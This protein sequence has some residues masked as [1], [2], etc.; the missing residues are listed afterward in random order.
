MLR[1]RE[2]LLGHPSWQVSSAA[3]LRNGRVMYAIVAAL[4][5]ARGLPPCSSSDQ[6]VWHS[7]GRLVLACSDPLATRGI[8]ARRTAM[9]PPH[10]VEGAQLWR[11]ALRRLQRLLSSAND[12]IAA[13]RTQRPYG[14][15]RCRA[16]R[17]AASERRSDPQRVY[18][19]CVR[20]ARHGCYV[21]SYGVVRSGAT[22][23]SVRG[24]GRRWK[25]PPAAA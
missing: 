10:A 17:R 15:A 21:H 18:Q 14:C 16:A 25:P 19:P 12:L 23:C 4:E 1:M 9:Q 20:Q 11:F 5:L 8:M 7:C 22:Q 13:H 3:D 6:S 24:G 2:M